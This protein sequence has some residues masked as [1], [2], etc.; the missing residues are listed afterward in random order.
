MLPFEC[1]G[2]WHSPGLPPVAGTLRVS[3][4]GRML[5]SLIGSLGSPGLN[6]EKRNTLIL[7]VVDGS[8]GPEVTLTNCFAVGSNWGTST[9]PREEYR[10]NQGF[11]GAHLVEPTD[12]AFQ[13]VEMRLGVLDVWADSL[14]GFRQEFGFRVQSDDPTS[15]LQYVMP[16]PVGGRIPG[17]ELSLGCQMS[18]SGMGRH[19]TFTEQ[20]LLS[21]SLDSP[22]SDLDINKTFV[23]P[24]Q[25]LFT[26]VADRAQELE[27]LYLLRDDSIATV[28]SNARIRY[29]AAR[30]FPRDLEKRETL[31]PFEL[32]FRLGDINI[33]FNV[34]IERWM[35]LVTEHAAACDVFFGLQYA[36]PGYLDVEFLGLVESLCLFYVSTTEGDFCQKAEMERLNQVAA[37]LPSD[38]ADWVRSRVES[39]PFPPLRN[40]LQNLLDQHSSLMTPLLHSDTQRFIENVTATLAYSLCRKQEQRSAASQGSDL[41]WMTVRLRTLLKLCFLQ[42]LGF[43]Q[44]QVATLL[45]QNQQYSFLSRMV[46]ERKNAP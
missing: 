9:G 1:S 39:R 46:K 2:H 8:L 27:E 34:F 10:A 44:E 26:F 13:R 6:Q 14:S 28:S 37:K 4:D 17:G 15:L 16:V 19:H 32:L 24:L 45:H 23:S 41:Y 21:V 12:F 38:D 30:V 11:F 3:E 18:T 40:V 25:N 33:E 43:V 36:P 35:K 5:L 31:Y 20:I 29:I 7:G 42:E 22:L